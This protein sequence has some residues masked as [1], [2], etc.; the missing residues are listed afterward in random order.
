M[1]ETRLVEKS[2]DEYFMGGGG[3]RRYFCLIPMKGFV[4]SSAAKC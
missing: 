2:T 3:R 4:R 1:E